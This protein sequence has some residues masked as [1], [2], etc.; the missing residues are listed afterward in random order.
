MN[1]KEI[2]E[3]LTLLT[4]AFGMFKSTPEGRARRAAIRLEKDR[5][6][7]LK[8]RNKFAQKMRDDV[9]D[10]KITWSQYEAILADYDNIN[11]VP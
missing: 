3:I 8:D 7:H 2:K 4:F 11:P 6:D 1:L 5:R 9:A 10:E